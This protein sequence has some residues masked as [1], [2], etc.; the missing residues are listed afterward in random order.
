MTPTRLGRYDACVILGSILFLCLMLWS[1]K[2][3]PFLLGG[4]QQLFWTNALRMLQGELIY[5]DF[6]EFTP[7]GAD[8]LYLTAFKLLGA[9][10]WVPNAVGL[11]IGTTLCWLCFRL[12]R[13]IMQ[14]APALLAAGLVLVPDYGYWLDATHHWFSVLCVL[15]AAAA[16]MPGRTRSRILIA[17]ALCGLA[18]FFT[19][20]RGVA[21][22]VGFAAFL[23]WEGLW[24]RQAWRV[25]LERWGLLLLGFA[26]A[27]LAFSSYF[28]IEAGVS[29]IWYFQVIHVLRYVNTEWYTLL[30]A[31]GGPVGWPLHSA[32]LAIALPI[33]YALTLWRQGRTPGGAALLAFAG[34]S[35]LA[36][37]A[38]NPN[39]LRVD[40]V[41]IP[42]ILLLVWLLAGEDRAPSRCRNCAI[43]ICWLVIVGLSAHRIWHRNV[44]RSAIADLPAG[45]VAA[46]PATALKLDWIARH[47][48]PGQYFCEATYW[49][50]YLPLSLRV[51]LF[52]SLD[53]QTS[54]E[55]LDK[56]LQQLE[57][58]HVRYVLWSPLD[59]PRFPKFEQFLS[60]RYR[61]VHEFA[62][63]DQIWELQP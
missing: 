60:G 9:R 11:V 34:A 12:A 3:T 51:P 16:L 50:V 10:L 23:L 53:V 24:T 43:T 55:F 6:Y 48:A 56:D 28:L 32:C 54:P 20:T 62:G 39:P 4:D 27:W 42:G 59:R 30:T 45:R 15:G 8:V 52:A 40:C 5:R 25:L 33:I 47:T 61:L 7:P 57:A 35:M 19:Q 29:R 49:S 41:A 21:A 17:G 26:A 58:T 2:M 38:L 36:E 63:Q 44:E 22:A 37:V 1:L 18:S 31:G 46:L 14:P 13:S